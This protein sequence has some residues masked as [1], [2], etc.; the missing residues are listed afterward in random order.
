M[1]LINEF[2]EFAMKGSVVDLAVGVIIGAAFG[3]VVTSLVENVMM[4]PLGYLIGKVDF[5]Q[6]SIN[7]PTDTDPVEIKYGMFVNAVIKFLIQAFAI[8]MVIKVMNSLNRKK[9]EVA[10]EPETPE[11]STEEKLLTEIRDL[12]SDKPATS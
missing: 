11:L 1:G 2:K 7:L 3:A 12:L 10:E 6:L 4:P 9:D 5:S 8:F